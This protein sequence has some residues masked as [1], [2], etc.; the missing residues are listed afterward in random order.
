M[1]SPPAES[2]KGGPRPDGS[3]THSVPATDGVAGNGD[4]QTFA[5]ATGGPATA[6][7]GPELSAPF[8]GPSPTGRSAFA[9]DALVA[10]S[11]YGPHPSRSGISGETA[12]ATPAAAERV[13]AL[14]ARSPAS[15]A[16]DH[17]GS[18]VRKE[19]SRE[20]SASAVRSSEPADDSPSRE[21]QPPR[22]TLFLA[23]AGAGA[24]IAAIC[25]RWIPDTKRRHAA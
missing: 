9:T 15:S 22:W 5:P 25:R 4:E 6:D 21:N 17:A 1:T 14:P 20:A 23:F 8:T 13:A 18:R 2:T 16:T 10:S 12:D 11:E 24:L 19:A 7:A 3:Q